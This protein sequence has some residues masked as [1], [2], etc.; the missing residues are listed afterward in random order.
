[1]AERR[2]QMVSP[3]A[4]QLPKLK[5]HAAHPAWHEASALLGMARDMQQ[6]QIQITA[7][8]QKN[9]IEE[10]MD[11]DDDD[12]EEEDCSRALLAV[13]RH[14]PQLNLAIGLRSTDYDE[15]QYMDL[16]CACGKAYVPRIEA[17]EEAWR[18][19]DTDRLRLEAHA[20]RGSLASIGAEA[21]S[22][23]AGSLE[24]AVLDKHMALVRLQLP[25]F[26]RD[27]RAFI[28]AIHRCLEARDAVI[29]SLDTYPTMWRDTVEALYRCVLAYDYT[30]ALPL[31]ASLE[32]AHA[33]QDGPWL[34]AMR[35]ALEEFDYQGLMRLLQTLPKE[36]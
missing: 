13:S 21:L 7:Q 12:Q 18:T 20:L 30:G 2:V 24:M 19:E 6:M 9:E 5:R 8:A 26:L 25:S 33:P 29:P 31:L 11:D 23:A 17:L 22:A 32:W 16:L 28:A 1:M 14:L 27:L 4:I 35:Q 36:A 15:A 3:Q 34:A 10:T